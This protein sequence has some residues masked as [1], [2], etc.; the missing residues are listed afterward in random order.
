MEI[1][2]D[3]YEDYLKEEYLSVHEAAEML[4]ISEDELRLLAHDHKIPS[5]N[6]AG[7]F[8]RLKKKEVE[9]LKNK[10]RIG[11][12]DLFPAGHEHALPEVVEKPNLREKLSD[13]WYFNDFY[14]LCSVIIVVLLWLIVASQ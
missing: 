8:L 1:K 13:F 12:H 6:I 4:E 9:D 7:V 11:R 5:H 3:E 10:W 2:P 14:I